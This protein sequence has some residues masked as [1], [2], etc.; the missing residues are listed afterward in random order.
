MKGLEKFL[1]A[2]GAFCSGGFSGRWGVEFDECGVIRNSK[3][4]VEL[5]GRRRLQRLLV[6]VLDK[7]L[8]CEM[9]KNILF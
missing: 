1:G 6:C 2:A 5:W 9:S 7:N 3:A 8:I 4:V